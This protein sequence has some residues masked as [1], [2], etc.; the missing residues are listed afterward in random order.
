MIF[1]PNIANALKAEIARV[2]R[3]EVRAAT[4]PLKKAAVQQRQVVAALRKKMAEL[5]KNSRRT[6]RGS[7]SK[8]PASAVGG[9][10]PRRRFSPARLAK[11]RAKLGLS[12]ADYGRLA[13]V[14]GQTIYKWEQGAARPRAAQLQALASVRSVGKREASSRLAETSA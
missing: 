7:P 13:G 5:E 1:M 9:E 14:S 3:K 2:A 11:H 10:G 4:E 8:A 12:A 6:A